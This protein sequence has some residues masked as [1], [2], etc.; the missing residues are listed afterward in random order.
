MPYARRVILPT[1]L[2]TEVC[3]KH[4]DGAISQ[5]IPTT[6]STN[7]TTY[8][9][10]TV[11]DG[12]NRLPVVL[13]GNGAPW[14]EACLYILSR[15]ESAYRPH[16]STYSSIA[17]DLTHF[18][19]FLES[20]DIDFTHFPKSKP[21]RPTYRYRAHLELHI[22]CGEIS[23]GTARRRIS[24]VVNFYRWLNVED[25]LKPENSPWKESEK[26]FQY[27]DSK[28]FFHYKNVKTTDLK[29]NIPQQ[30]MTFSQDIDDGGKLRP[31]TPEEQKQVLMALKAL[32]NTEMSLVF[33]LALFTGARMQSIL[34][35]RLRHVQLVIPDNVFEIPLLI[36]PGTSI[37]TKNDK[38]M[39]L[40]VPIWLMNSLR[41]YSISDRAMRRRNLAGNHDD[42]HYLFLSRNG[43]PL[44]LSKVDQQFSADNSSHR[45]ASGE[46]IRQF[47]NDRIMPQIKLQCG[48]NMKFRFH[49]LR[50]SFGMNLTESQMKL[51]E[52]GKTTLHKMRLYVKDRMG[53]SSI[54]TTD[55]YLNYGNNK[56]YAL[57]AQS[58]YESYLMNLI[59]TC[60]SAL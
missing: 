60:E 19:R 42:D 26:L 4:D 28:G 59:A 51:V 10:K 52:C 34:T 36:G 50:A 17:D 20:D 40:F 44:Y 15:L 30:A 24:S 31:L 23:P 3:D 37:D 18:R 32:K 7:V 46:A 6:S 8:Y 22:H 9:T 53:H 12:Y 25:I 45:S 35:L 2:L 39:T 33:W 43:K 29:I 11:G 1:F 27:K 21:F 38:R 58:D 56:V 48:L 41:I 49:D 13:Q 14:Q 57:Q 16:M 55:L 47:L 54:T 5:T